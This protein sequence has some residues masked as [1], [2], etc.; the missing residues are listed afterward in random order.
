[1]DTVIRLRRPVD[2]NANDGARFEVHY[3]K[4]RG[5]YGC[6]AEPFEAL[7]TDGSWQ[8][9]EIVSADSDEAIQKLRDE[10]MSL[11]DIAERLGMS[12]SAVSRKLNGSR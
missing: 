3:T 7:L 8:V 4:A 5:F 11:R 2:Y 6:D 10:G 9:G 12:K 1:L